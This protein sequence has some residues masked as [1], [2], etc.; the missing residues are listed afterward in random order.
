MGRA[1]IVALLAI[2]LLTTGSSC[3]VSSNNGRTTIVATDYAA[4]VGAAVMLVGIGI[5]CI[6]ETEECFPDEE[7]LQAQADAFER[8]RATYTAGLRH[9]QNG[10]P[11]GLEWIC[12]SAHQGYAGAQYYYGAHLY[13]EGPEHEAEG[14]EWLWQAAAQGHQQADIMLRQVAG[15]SPRSA[16]NGHTADPAA[17]LPSIRECAATEAVVAQEDAAPQ[18]DVGGQ[19]DAATQEDEATEPI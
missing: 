9:H 3:S 7:A 5:Y 2:W 11:K 17:A 6:A 13:K 14:V 15:V 10:D 12:L 16:A 18:D 4:A 1:S 8:A 19:E